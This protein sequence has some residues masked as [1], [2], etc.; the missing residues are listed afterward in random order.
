LLEREERK[1]ER[2]Q[3]RKKT[4]T[5]TNKQTNIGHDLKGL[6]SYMNCGIQDLHFPL[7]CLVDYR[8]FRLIAMSIL[9]IDETT[10]Q[11]GSW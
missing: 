9:P 11:Y 2:W 8:G 4:N 1:K 7:M 10:I 5:H 3:K 6:G